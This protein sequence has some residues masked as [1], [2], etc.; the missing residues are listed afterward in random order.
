MGKDRTARAIT[1]LPRP[2][3]TLLVLLLGAAVG[4]VAATYAW[5]HWIPHQLCADP[6]FAGRYQH[7]SCVAVPPPL[8]L[9]VTMMTAGILL[10][11]GIREIVPRWSRRRW[12]KTQLRSR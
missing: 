5:D 6:P 9:N 1:A 7:P 8:W 3:T 12:E 2:I 10:A 4:A 11:L